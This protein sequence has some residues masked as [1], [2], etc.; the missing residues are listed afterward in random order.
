LFRPPG[1]KYRS[2]IDQLGPFPAALGAGGK[3]TE[4]DK[5]Q[6]SKFLNYPIKREL[7]SG[8]GLPPAALEGGL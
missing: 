1:K 7:F 5:I 4:A 3:T 8:Q 6:K 2:S